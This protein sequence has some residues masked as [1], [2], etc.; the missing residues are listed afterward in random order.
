MV[1][2][3]YSKFPNS[4]IYFKRIRRFYIIYTLDWDEKDPMVTN[5]D[6]EEMQY[7]IN[8]VLGSKNEYLKRKSRSI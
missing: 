1:R 5:K 6:R 3:Y 7:L 2:G 8:E 4:V